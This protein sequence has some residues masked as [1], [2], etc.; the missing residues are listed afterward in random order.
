MGT[1]MIWWS[2]NKN[3]NK[4]KYSN[5]YNFEFT[6]WVEKMLIKIKS[7]KHKKYKVKKV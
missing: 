7:I 2:K 3:D 1:R 5:S 6:L 4:K